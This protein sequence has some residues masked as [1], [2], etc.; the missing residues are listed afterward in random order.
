MQTTWR[1]ETAFRT[2]GYTTQRRA[3]PTS[4][5]Q[6][7]EDFRDMYNLHQPEELS[8]SED[9]ESQMDEDNTQFRSEDLCDSSFAFHSENRTERVRSSSVIGDLIDD[10]MAAFA[11]EPPLRASNNAWSANPQP[12]LGVCVENHDAQDAHEQHVGFDSEGTSQASEVYVEYTSE[13]ET[14]FGSGRSSTNNEYGG[15]SYQVQVDAIGEPYTRYVLQQQDDTSWQGISEPHEPEDVQHSTEVPDVGGPGNSFFLDHV[16]NQM[17]SAI[18]PL[19]T[20]IDHPLP[21]ISSEPWNA[22]HVSY[23]TPVGYNQTQFHNSSAS[24]QLPSSQNLSYG[25][26]SSRSIEPTWVSNSSY[27]FNHIAT[28]DNTNTNRRSLTPGN[29]EQVSQSKSHASGNSVH[30]NP[31]PMIVRDPP[32]TA[33]GHKIS[34]VEADTY[35][36]YVVQGHESRACADPVQVPLSPSNPR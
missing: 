31:G 15:Q 28:T 5:I 3:S 22:L 7:A 14:G 32:F 30:T 20:S 29:L 21:W 19:Q 9:P 4:F 17:I 34:C 2:E 23:G 11:S 16:G 13:N 1:A 26:V 36:R 18:T 10:P 12:L 8:G 6:R 35:P 24:S 25:A 33:N 27:R